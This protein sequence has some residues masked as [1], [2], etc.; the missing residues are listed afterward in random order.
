LRLKPSMKTNIGSRRNGV[1]G[2]FCKT[3][4][5]ILLRRYGQNISYY[6]RL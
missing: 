2:V 6:E 4:R 5:N 1:A 3:L